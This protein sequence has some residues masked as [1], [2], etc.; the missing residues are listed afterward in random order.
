MGKINNRVEV[1]FRESVF[2]L[3]IEGELLPVDKNSG[4]IIPVRENKKYKDIEMCG[5]RMG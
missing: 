5:I 3:N 2:E 1:S 4:N